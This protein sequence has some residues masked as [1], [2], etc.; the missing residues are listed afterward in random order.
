MSIKFRGD[1]SRNRFQ[2]PL[3]PLRAKSQCVSS[4]SPWLPQQPLVQLRTNP[5]ALPSRLVK[6]S[7]KEVSSEWT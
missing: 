4:P 3:R 5:A 1:A 6:E 7:G 2:R